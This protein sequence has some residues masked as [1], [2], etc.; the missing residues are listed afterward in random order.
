MITMLYNR[1]TGIYTFG[2]NTFPRRIRCRLNLGH[3]FWGKKCV[4]WA[5]EYGTYCL[6][7]FLACASQGMPSLSAYSRGLC[8]NETRNETLILMVSVL[9]YNFTVKYTTFFT[10][11]NHCVL[12]CLRHIGQILISSPSNVRWLVKQWR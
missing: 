8:K 9:C 3:I 4:I 7:S 6:H 5:R 1:C 11:T 10:Q 2:N 12:C